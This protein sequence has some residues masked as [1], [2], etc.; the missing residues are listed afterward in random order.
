MVMGC[1]N[2]GMVFFVE[3]VCF[4]FI[5]VVGFFFGI[6]VLLGIWNL[7]NGVYKLVVVEDEFDI[8]V[9]CGVIWEFLRLKFCW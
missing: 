4:C 1:G 2:I 8:F 7:G 6:I 3:I 9:E 5:I